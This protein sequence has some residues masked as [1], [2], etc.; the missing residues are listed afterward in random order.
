M[1]GYAVF[2]YRHSGLT[3]PLVADAYRAAMKSQLEGSAS[4]K[5]CCDK[6]REA[7]R[8]GKPCDPRADVDCDG[9]PNRKDASQNGQLPDIDS[10]VNAENAPIDV[11]P[12]GFDTSNPDFLP[13]RTARNSRGV[14]DC[15]CKWELIKGDLTC[16]PDGKQKHHYQA[17]WRC[18]TTGAEVI[19]VRYAS[20]TAYCEKQRREQSR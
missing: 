5:V 15:P 16:S 2:S 8:S 12:S 7:V 10:F 14:G 18:P 17:T 6:F 11:F 20:P 1:C 4:S 3:D 9:T 13:D 19:T